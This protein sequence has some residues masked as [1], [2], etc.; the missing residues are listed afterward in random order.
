[1]SIVVPVNLDNFCSCM[2]LY[3]RFSYKPEHS[4][5]NVLGRGEMTG[6]S[7]L[8]L[9]SQLKIFMNDGREWFDITKCFFIE[10]YIFH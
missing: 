3:Q 4:C 8:F 10:S 7:N 2:H 1:M 6:I 9:T 5:A